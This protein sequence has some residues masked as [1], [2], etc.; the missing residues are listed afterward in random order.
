MHFAGVRRRSR[1]QEP[2]GVSGLSLHH[3]LGLRGAVCVALPAKPGRDALARRAATGAVLCT[4]LLEH[5]GRDRHVV[6]REGHPAY[7]RRPTRPPAVSALPVAPHLTASWRSMVLW[8]RDARE[9]ANGC[10]SARRGASTAR[11]VPQPCPSSCF[12]ERRLPGCAWKAAGFASH[13]PA[14]HHRGDVEEIG[15]RVLGL[16]PRLRTPSC[17]PAGDRC[18]ARLLLAWSAM[19]SPSPPSAG[20]CSHRWRRLQWRQD[21]V[22][23]ACWRR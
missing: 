15:D 23:V 17:L 9:P 1:A 11:T 8:A 16:A 18:R 2:G 4:P 6:V 10:V 22:P 5:P 3:F 20:P 19:S 21:S 14:L 12:Q 7:I 13:F